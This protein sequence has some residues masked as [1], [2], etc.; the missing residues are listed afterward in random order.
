[1]A[2]NKKVSELDSIQNLSDNDEFVVID[3]SV[4]FGEDA[5]STE[6]HQKFHWHN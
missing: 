4:A 6:K 1:M 3:K 2:E 5:S